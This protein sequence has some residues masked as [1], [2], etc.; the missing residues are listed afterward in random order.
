MYSLISDGFK[1]IEPTAQT[2]ES[3][4]AFA[5][6]QG[7]QGIR[8][9]SIKEGLNDGETA[10]IDYDVIFISKGKEVPYQST[11]T[12]RYRTNDQQPGWKLIH[13]YGNNIDTS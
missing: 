4:E 2:Y 12:L 11:F 7:I 3:F 1:K 10:A 9:K 6:K 8:I 5:K 13:P